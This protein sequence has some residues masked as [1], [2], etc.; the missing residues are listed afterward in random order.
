MIISR[1]LN[2]QLFN[3]T[4][5]IFFVLVIIGLSNEFLEYLGQVASGDFPIELVAK[6]LF[7][8]MPKLV[9][10]LLP[11]A[12]FLGIVLTLGRLYSN[13]EMIILFS[14]GLTWRRL[15]Q[16]TL[17]M[18]LIFTV[19]ILFLNLFISPMFMKKQENLLE[20]AKLNLSMKIIL[21]GKFQ[22]SPKGEYVFYSEAKDSKTGAAKEV[23]IAELPPKTDDKFDIDQVAKRV[24]IGKEANRA[25][26][27]QYNGEFLVINEGHSY[28]LNPNDAA[29]RQ[30]KFD[31]LGVRL[32]EK[33]EKPSLSLESTSTMQLI[34]NS[35]PDQEKIAE[36]Q[37]RYSAPFAYLVIALLAIPFGQVDLRKGRNWNSFI[38]IIVIVI[39]TSG[40]LVAR[41]WLAR[42]ITPNWLG[43]WWVHWVA[44]ILALILLGFNSGYFKIIKN[45][46]FK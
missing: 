4:I 5:A 28:E 14:T 7:Y 40:L 26:D 39:Y 2:R 18:G 43:V 11:F 37:W 16:I 8:S 44:I 35:T 36:L 29:G 12:F 20:H 27:E 30:F 41:S 31:E 42:G 23:F 15:S 21:P 13:S 9:S 22:Q 10:T 34:N 32:T 46:L 45:K 3:T 24:V 19:V 6:L 1:Y 38:S 25:L 33:K 17:F